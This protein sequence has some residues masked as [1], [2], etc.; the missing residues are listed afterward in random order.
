MASGYDVG[1]PQGLDQTVVEFERL[2]GLGRLV[3]LHAND[4]KVSLGSGK[5]RHENIGEGTIGEKG[6]GRVV[7][8]PK[9]K[10]LPFILETP[11][12]D[13]EE[14]AVQEVAKLKRLARE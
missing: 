8:H 6:L 11:A 5:D 10:H 14:T 12:L 2:I 13:K 9:L 4:S 1:S 3:V 7:N